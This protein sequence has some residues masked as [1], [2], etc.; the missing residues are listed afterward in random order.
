M[1]HTKLRLS[2]YVVFTV[3]VKT[4]GLFTGRDSIVK[5]TFWQKKILSVPFLTQQPKVTCFLLSK[6]P[7]KLTFSDKV[8]PI[9]TTAFNIQKL[10]VLFTQCIWLSRMSWNKQPLSPY[11][12]SDG[13][14]CLYEHKLRLSH[15]KIWTVIIIRMNLRVR[16]LT[17]KNFGNTERSEEE[18]TREV[19]SMCIFYF[20]DPLSMA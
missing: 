14:D 20:Y 9:N 17:K 16:V 8:V 1:T 18:T 15:R 10:F 2:R 19:V 5:R 7:N 4:R 12:A 11:I 13:W 6:W 3:A